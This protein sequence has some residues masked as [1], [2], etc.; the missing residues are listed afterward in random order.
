MI[1]L[2]L[3]ETFYVVNIWMGNLDKNLFNSVPCSKTLIILIRLQIRPSF[4]R[5]M[6]KVLV[7]WTYDCKWIDK[8]KINYTYHPSS[9]RSQLYS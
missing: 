6:F 3:L 1:L 9:K 2:F 4:H 7:L 8:L 5:N